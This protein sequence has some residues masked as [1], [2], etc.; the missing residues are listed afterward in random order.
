M[1]VTVILDGNTS[2]PPFFMDVGETT[3]LETFKAFVQAEFGIDPRNQL[4]SCNGKVMD[5]SSSTLKDMGVSDSDLI[6]LKVVEAT[7]TAS[8]NSTSAPPPAASKNDS[9]DFRGL[10]L[11]DIPPGCPPARMKKIIMANPIELRRLK[12]TNPKL[13]EAVEDPDPKKLEMHLLEVEMDRASRLVEAQQKE[14][15]LRQRLVANPMDVEAQREMEKMIQQQNIH[16]NME[17]ALE[18]TPESF[19]RVTMLYV[20]CEV[21]GVPVKAFVDSGAQSTIMSE[22]CARRCNLMRLVDTR[23]EGTAVGVGSAKILGRV[24]MAQLKMGSLFFNCTFTVM[25]NQHHTSQ[26]EFLFGLDM[27]RRHRCCIDLKNNCLCLEGVTGIER[28]RFLNESELSKVNLGN[29]SGGGEGDRANSTGQKRA[30]EEPTAAPRTSING[31]GGNSS[32]PL[33]ASTTV[34]TTA[35]PSGGPI[36]LDDLDFAMSSIK[37][38]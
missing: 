2:R 11:E 34:T 38:K 37:P 28:V 25:E 20:D 29:P 27:L 10:T 16:K 23:F 30:R 14:R 4:L 15:R 33:S 32:L 9:E 7:P 31:G 24:H 36:T 17:L 21:N 13:A 8:G 35:S 26:H 22:S 3:N 12:F 18:H 5:G 1:K 6:L 19:S